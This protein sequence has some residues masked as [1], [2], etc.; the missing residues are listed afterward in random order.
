[1]EQAAKHIVFLGRV[2]GMGFRFTALNIANRYRLTGYVRN[3]P[4]GN[5]EM[6]VQGPAET[7]DNCVCDI[8]DSFSGC[9][10]QTDVE[11]VTL[12]PNLTDF[13]ITF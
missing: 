5:V 13:K 6:L 9:V 11:I 4:N 8:Q 3:L 7:I 10:R 1:M 12:D 2:Q